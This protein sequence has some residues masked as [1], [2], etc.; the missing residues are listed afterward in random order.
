MRISDWSSDVCSSDLNTNFGSAFGKLNVKEVFAEAQVP[1]FK[2]QPLAEELSLNGAFRLTDYSNSGSVKTWKVGAV[3]KPIEDVMF[4]VTRSRD[5]RA[6]SLFELFAGVQT[7]D[8]KR[9]RLNSSH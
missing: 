3:Y 8:R 6:P 9:T 1:I 4:R 5:I 7:A 2:G